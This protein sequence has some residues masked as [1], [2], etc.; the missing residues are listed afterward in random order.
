M[1]HGEKER[2]A[3]MIRFSLVESVCGILVA[4]NAAG[5]QTGRPGAVRAGED[6]A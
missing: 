6:Y 2:R 4:D 3:I 1:V 5:A